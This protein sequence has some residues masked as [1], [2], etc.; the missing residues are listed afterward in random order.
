MIELKDVVK[1]YQR[2]AEKVY[3]LKNINLRIERGEFIAIVGPSG[4]G[5]TTLLHILG[6]LDKPTSGTVKFNGIEINRMSEADLLK[7]R[8]N[9]IGFVFQHFYLIPNLNVWEN[10]TLPLLFSRK[11]TEREKIYSLL[12]SVGLK[13]KIY[14]P[15]NKLSGGE[16]QRV[17]IARA[18]INEPELVLADEPTGNLDTENSERIFE[19]FKLLNIKGITVVI[20]TH[21]NDIARRVDRVITLRDGKIVD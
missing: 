7:I 13:E 15:V 14:H 12:E 18:L 2:G 8:R 1:V 17:A 10:V 11:K 16:M 9:K 4:S 6:C 19:L 21:N 3:A 20:V 5:K